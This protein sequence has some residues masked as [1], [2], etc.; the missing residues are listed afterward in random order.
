MAYLSGSDHLLNA[1][2]CR[3]AGVSPWYPLTAYIGTQRVF[4]FNFLCPCIERHCGL[5]SFRQVQN[6]FNELVGIR[7][8]LLS[9]RLIPRH[10]RRDDQRWYGGR[11]S[12]TI[13]QHKTFHAGKT[14]P[15]LVDRFKRIN[16]RLEAKSPVS[17]NDIYMAVPDN[18][19]NNCQNN[20]TQK[21][22]KNGVVTVTICG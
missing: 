9:G 20:T 8:L 4:A 16:A 2:R 3:C 7:L 10:T 19:L 21:K 22:E 18:D 13:R 14:F 11:I 15:G 12:C 6:I 5:L 17:R 1:R